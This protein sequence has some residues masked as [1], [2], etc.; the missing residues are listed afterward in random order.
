MPQVSHVGREIARH[1]VF[2]RRR[3]NSD[4]SALRARHESAVTHLH[5]QLF[6]GVRMFDAQVTFGVVV[7]DLRFHVV[8]GPGIAWNSHAQSRHHKNTLCP[9][10]SS[11][12]PLPVESNG[13]RDRTYSA[14]IP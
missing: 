1:K 14:G 10:R 12:R 3:K 2:V 9:T 8:A 11:T 6:R 13:S 4:A 5:G 7:G